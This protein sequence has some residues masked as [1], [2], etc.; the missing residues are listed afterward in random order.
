[1]FKHVNAM[2]TKTLVSAVIGTLSFSATAATVSNPVSDGSI[3]IDAGITDW[4]SIAS[5]GYD[6]DTLSDV[7]VKAD[8]L[9]GWM[10]H[11]NDNLYVAY[12]NNG[13]IDTAN[14]WSWQVYFNTDDLPS[15][16]Y[17]A[18][19]TGGAEYLLQ[20]SNIYQ[21]T[22]T[23]NDWSWQFLT[24]VANASNGP[25]AEFKIPRSALE[26]PEQVRT[27]FKARNSAFTGTY[28]LSGIDT[29]PKALAPL[30]LH[31]DL[32][33]RQSSIWPEVGGTQSMQLATDAAA[34]DLQLE[35]AAQYPLLEGQLITYLG[36]DT[37]YYTAQVA[38]LSG[39]TITLKNALQAPVIAGQ[40]VW[41]FYE[42]GAHPNE[43]GYRAIADFAIREVG[44]SNLNTGKHVLLGDSWFDKPG[45]SERLSER[46]EN[47]EIINQG[48]GGSTS[49]D[50]LSRFDADVTPLNPDFV[51]VIAGVNDYHQDVPLATYLSNMQGIITKIHS[52]GA[53]G[54]IF[55]SPVGQLF[56][57]SDE[58]Q[59][60]SHRYSEA[61]A[62]NSDHYI[63]Y[64]FAA[65]PPPPPSDTISNPKTI[66]IDGA[67]TDWSELQSF[68][69]DG[70]DI[71]LPGARAD[72]I[73]AW[74]AH[75]D[76]NFYLAYRND[77]NIDEGTWWPWQTYL[78]IDSDDATGYQ[79]GNGVGAEFVIQGGALYRYIGTGSDWAWQ[80]TV[81][82][83]YKVIADTAELALPRL[84]IGNP[85][86][87]SLVMKTRNGVFTSNYSQ[88]SID[89]YPNGSANLNYQ[90][91]D[92]V[93][94]GTLSN[95]VDDF[96]IT[97]DGTLNDWSTVTSFG[98]DLDDIADAPVQADWLEVWAAHD[99][100][101]LYIAY[102]NDGVI[103]PIAWSYQAYIDVDNDPSTGFKVTGSI[104]A[105]FLLEGP[106]LSRY[107]GTGNN[108]DW[109]AVPVTGSSII[110][111]T[112]EIAIPR[113]ILGTTD[114]RVIFKGNNSPYTNSFDPSGVD[115]FPDNAASSDDGYFA[116]SMP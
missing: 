103:S 90:F 96:S 6:A 25:I 42:D 113:S 36:S 5:F 46:L 9:E 34:G 18:L 109:L 17:Q 44:L 106:S 92:T 3:V 13:D 37:E 68:G 84:D 65:V 33:Y 58:R 89:S 32:L 54:V 78:D 12:R 93:V 16:G 111:D 53:E 57:G 23:G 62:N 69:L 82:A 67:L 75:D 39:T 11:D 28:T 48:I 108:W 73:E 63:D 81:S 19:D 61:L 30:T 80:Y 56:Y 97:L 14:W 45:V 51:W 59:Q 88:A 72:F 29:Y 10:A 47:A 77:G 71:S 86:N 50:L 26:N 1:M 41:N 91:S 4:A 98:Q 101:N 15:T 24:S 27:I 31:D 107:Q 64:Q 83:E 70:D 43:Q 95:S 7:G 20:A 38:S 21:Y 74:M 52:I 100:N 35:M 105:E 79:I 99:T 66:T 94:D 102:K 85:S 76:T 40:N 110:D 116:Y 114:F 87:M 55:D 112:A 104:G 22:G 8:Y 2:L 115:H 60:L 49:A